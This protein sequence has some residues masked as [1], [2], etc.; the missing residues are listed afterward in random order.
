MKKHNTLVI[1]G[2]VSA[3]IIF[4]A[5]LIGPSFNRLFIGD[6]PVQGSSIASP[7]ITLSVDH[8]AVNKTSDNAVQLHTIFAAHNPGKNTVMLDNVQ[9]GIYVNNNTKI[10][11][12][13]IGWETDD[14][15]HGQES[16]YPVIAGDTL[17]ISDEQTLT[18][19]A[20]HND[21]TLWHSIVNGNASYVIR[22]IYMIRE[23]S[24]LQASGNQKD[25]EIPY[26]QHQNSNNHTSGV[27]FVKSLQ[28]PQVQGRIDH[29]SIDVAGKRLFIAELG[30]NSVDVINLSSGN[31]IH[32]ITTGL[33]EPQGILFVPK[34]DKIFISNGGDGTVR[35][36]NATSYSLIKST[37]LEGDADN[38]MYDDGTGLIYVGYGD[39]ALAVLN[40]NGSRIADISLPGHPE[41]FQIEE[42]GNRIFVNVP[43]DHSIVLADKQAHSVIK[44]WRMNDASQ[45]FPMALDD[46]NRRLFVGF[47]D[48]AKLVI[49]DT[50]SGKAMASLDVS[51]DA[52][53]IFYNSLQK[54]VYLSAGEGF[55]DIFRQLDPDH[56]GALTK[57]S[58][59]PG[60]RTSL[61]VPELHS[62]YVASPEQVQGQGAQ[63]LMY[64]IR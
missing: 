64:E 9:Y 19:S 13:S 5:L 42:S 44:K 55:L 15:I 51:K 39:G 58:T 37:R 60:A 56:Y 23:D 6:E 50:E 27:T 20:V 1:G 22:G 24:E 14:V 54:Q 11:S 8:M 36:Y 3:L 21:E 32:S 34:F 59:V 48:P 47:R 57:I 41:S 46:H 17:R 16:V 30:N 45:N 4:F 29:M 18:K 40:S 7:V 38:I 49:Y 62:L 61:F 33:S 31:R 28:L 35:I 25:F 10:A 43:S 53:D 12:G 2:A 63:L 26:S 52:D